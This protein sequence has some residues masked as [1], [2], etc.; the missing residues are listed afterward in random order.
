MA[1]GSGGGA[2]L[3]ERKSRKGEEESGL[4]SESKNWGRWGLV[5]ELEPGV[6]LGPRWRRPLYTHRSQKVV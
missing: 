5:S 3:W 4:V 6:M 1:R 2:A